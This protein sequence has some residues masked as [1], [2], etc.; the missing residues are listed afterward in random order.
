MIELSA[1]VDWEPIRACFADLHSQQSELEQYLEDSFRE[2]DGVRRDLER[3]QHELH[4]QSEQFEQTRT[5]WEDTRE[6]SEQQAYL[7]QTA[8]LAALEKDYESTQAELVRMREMQRVVPQ[9]EFHG[10]N[11]EREEL[12]AELDAVRSR[13]AEL[14]E[15]LDQAKRESIED[16][17]AWSAELKQMRRVL[18][19][20]T[21]LWTNNLHPPATSVPATNPAS[22]PLG[23]N[24]GAAQ[25]MEDAVL[26]SVMAQFDKIR[27]ERAQRRVQRAPELT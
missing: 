24:G 14:S 5:E 1:L 3:M 15:A 25:N 7:E 18:E 16:R 21:D 26:G 19:R 22:G 17:A 13:A 11:Q 4:S 20:Q 6:N 2:L 23:G 12:E 9:N 8:K 10:Q 27:R